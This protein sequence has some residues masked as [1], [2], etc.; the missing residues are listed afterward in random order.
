MP[1]RTVKSPP[2]RP[3]GATAYAGKPRVLRLRT[4]PSAL[5]RSLKAPTW[6]ANPAAVCGC[7]LGSCELAGRVV[8]VA[9]VGVGVGVAAAAT[10]AVLGRGVGTGGSTVGLAARAA[11]VGA[12]LAVRDRSRPSSG[13]SD[14]SRAG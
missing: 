8:P 11:G 7:D 4:T 1:T 5:A 13:L 3:A 12:G 6:I 2:P 14:S 9:G 10:G